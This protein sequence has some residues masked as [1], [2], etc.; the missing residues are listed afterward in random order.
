MPN[1]KQCRIERDGMAIVCWVPDMFAMSGKSVELKS[2]SEWQ[3]KWKIAVVYDETSDE[4]LLIDQKT[5]IRSFRDA[6]SI[7]EE[8][9]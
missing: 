4:Q 8:T 2:E 1:Y 7:H 9:I 5:E 3:D 6:V